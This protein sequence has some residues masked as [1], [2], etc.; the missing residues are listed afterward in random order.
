MAIMTLFMYVPIIPSH[1]KIINCNF[2]FWYIPDFLNKIMK[3]EN[4][5]SLYLTHIY[6]KEKQTISDSHR[7]V[8]EGLNSQ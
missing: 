2:I 8:L 3:F 1:P 7:T 4:K 6:N 5:W